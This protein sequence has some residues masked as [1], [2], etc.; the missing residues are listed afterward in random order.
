MQQQVGDLEGYLVEVVIPGGLSTVWHRDE[1]LVNA[2]IR[3][4]LKSKTLCVAS[5]S[6]VALAAAVHADDTQFFLYG[7]VDGWSV[8][9]LMA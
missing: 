1:T 6:G 8:L 2:R 5:P 4:K 7:T 9:P 3:I